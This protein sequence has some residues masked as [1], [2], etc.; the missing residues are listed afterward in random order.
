MISAFPL[1]AARMRPMQI[2]AGH[3]R[4]AQPH[5]TT[6][7]EAPAYG[8]SSSSQLATVLEPVLMALTGSGVS[9]VIGSVV[10]GAFT[11]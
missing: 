1:A 6:N 10:A 8:Q 4:A 9:L 11:H 2:A 7:I 5:V 3:M